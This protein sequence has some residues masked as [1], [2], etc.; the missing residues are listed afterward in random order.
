MTITL[1]D[2]LPTITGEWSQ[3][4]VTAMADDIC[5]EL[6]LHGRAIL[7]LRL[8]FAALPD[9]QVV[10]KATRRLA[11]AP[12]VTETLLSTQQPLPGMPGR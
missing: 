8:Q 11:H 9:G 5:D 4:A 2:Y 6:K 1:P 7:T 10:C 12:D 3:N